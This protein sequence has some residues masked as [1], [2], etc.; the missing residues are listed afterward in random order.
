MDIHGCVGVA[1]SGM[2][3]TMLAPRIHVPTLALLGLSFTGCEPDEVDPLVGNWEAFEIDGSPFPAEGYDISIRLAITS[4][5]KG[6]YTYHYTYEDE[7][8]EEESRSIMVDVSAAPRYTLT[9]GESKEGNAGYVAHCELSGDEL[10]CD[11]ADAEIG[12]QSSRFKR[13]S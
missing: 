13:K 1:R 2:M 4:D 6:E 10:T 9:L 8:A 7:P 12:I 5:H 3:A 11:D